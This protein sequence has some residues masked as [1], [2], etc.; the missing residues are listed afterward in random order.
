MKLIKRIFLWTLSIIAVLAFVAYLAFNYISRMALPDY[1]KNVELT[2]LID[3]VQVFRDERAAPHIY[4]KNEH[5]LYMVTGYLM[6]QDRLWQMDLLRRVTLGRLSEIFGKDMAD[7]DQL[8]RAL[9]MSEKSESVLKNSEKVYLECLE[10]FAAGVNQYIEKQG[11]K[12]PPEF[13]VLS[14]KPEPW[15]PFHTLNL[16][17]YMAWD[18]AGSWQNEV[19]LHKLRQQ[20]DS[21]KLAQLYPDQE[22][23]KS[24]VHMDTESPA[25]VFSLLDGNNQLLDMGLEV[26]SASNNWAVSGSKSSTGK[27]L[28]ANDMHLGFGLPGIWYQMHQVIEGKLN[29]TGVALPGAPV[30]INGHNES[31]AW[32]MTNLT[33]DEMDFYY[34]TLHPDDPDKYLFNDEWLAVEVKKERILTKEGDTIFRENRFTHR[35]PIV[36]GFKKMENEVVSMRWIGNEFSNELRSMYLLNRAENWEQFRDALMTMNAISQN[37]VYADVHGNIGMQSTGGVALRN[38]E[39][40]IYL[41]PGHTDSTDWKGILPFEEM[42]FTF[43]PAEGQVSSANNK[44]IAEDYPYY[45]GYWFDFSARIDRIRTMLNE[46]EIFS[47]LDFMQMQADQQSVFASDYA[48]TITAIVSDSD[49]LSANELKALELL[50]SWNM[51]LDKESV[52]TTVFEKFYITF[53]QTV[54]IDELGEKQ[55]KELGSGL[56]RH[57]FEHIW[58]NPTS[59]WIDDVHSPEPESFEDIVFLSFRKAVK[60]LEENYGNEPDT[61]KWGN[62]HQLTLKHPLGRVEMLDKLLG[63]NKGPFPVGGSF[64]TVNPMAYPLHQSFN[65]VHGASQRHIYNPSNWEDSYVVIPTGISGIPA[66]SYYGNQADMFLKNEYYKEPWTK[67]D[68]IAGAK[69][70]AVFR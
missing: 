69:Y 25:D 42:P 33:I 58:R 39:N 10:A 5:D 30:I 64:H 49:S 35:G 65:V 7:T 55:F 56:L 47:P 23:L 53:L 18:L 41:N 13:I 70:K 50:T 36:S 22:S 21:E 67:E 9:R 66:S 28:L 44:T 62:L 6:A 8:L 68:V 1:N 17:G 34:E 29:V 16:I 12:L 15:Q 51:T 26:F 40:A 48:G 3:E 57:F 2:G 59:D 37:I 24:Y 20:L 4:A 45:I 19:V 61:W 32:G 60:S 27:P 38:P 46:K 31:I 63:L 11:S 52:A 54:M 14:Y 43:N